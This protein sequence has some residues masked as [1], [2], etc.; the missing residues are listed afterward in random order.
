M[1]SVVLIIAKCVEEIVYFL[2]WSSLYTCTSVIY[3]HICEIFHSWNTRKREPV[4]IWRTKTLLL[5]I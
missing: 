3:M 2:C 4:H 1:N 5:S